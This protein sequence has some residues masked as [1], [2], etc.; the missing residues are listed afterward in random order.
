M[1]LTK[2]LLIKKLVEQRQ[3]AKQEAEKFVEQFFEEICQALENEG[4]VKI[5]GLGTFHVHT[6]RERP[7][8]NPKTGEEVPVSARRTVVFHASD[9]LKER[10]EQS[11]GKD[12]DE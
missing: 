6:K 1:V 7:G 9:K 5:T 4:K 8:R 3:L 12:K 11:V 10:V 2:A